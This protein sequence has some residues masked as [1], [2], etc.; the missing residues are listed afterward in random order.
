MIKVARTQTTRQ[1]LLRSRPARIS[2][3]LAYKIARIC[4]EK[5]ESVRVVW[6]KEINASALGTQKDSVNILLKY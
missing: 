1:R 3:I 4:V 6:L 5:L 2:R